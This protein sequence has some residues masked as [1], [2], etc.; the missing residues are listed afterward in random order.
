MLLSLFDIETGVPLKT[1]IEQALKA[2]RDS[3]RTP[4][5]KQAST[6]DLSVKIESRSPKGDDDGFEP[7]ITTVAC[8]E[9]LTAQEACPLEEL[10]EQESNNTN[11]SPMLDSDDT[12]ENTKEDD[13]AKEPNAHR[14]LQSLLSSLAAS[15]VHE[16]TPSFNATD[17]S[18]Q[19]A[20]PLT[21]SAKV[22]VVPAHCQMEEPEVAVTQPIAA[23]TEG[24]DKIV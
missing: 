23:M 8:D 9:I 24:D 6:E 14:S 19:N 4:F 15:A 18:E 5:E 3:D 7:E 11:I 22:A 17:S 21:V 16:F 13:S 20:S 10:E 2:Q 12:C 1:Q